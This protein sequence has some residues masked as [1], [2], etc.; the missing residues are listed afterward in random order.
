MQI[1]DVLRHIPGAVVY[2]EEDKK[3]PCKE[4]GYWYYNDPSLLRYIP[5]SEGARQQAE[6]GVWGLAVCPMCRK[7][8]LWGTVPPLVQDAL[9]L[10]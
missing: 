2:Q 5:M 8:V 9:R 4:C 7:V 1:E 10:P 3:Y 6:L